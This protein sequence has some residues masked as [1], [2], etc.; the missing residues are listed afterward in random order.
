MF[1]KIKSINNFMDNT[2]IIGLIII[3]IF[4]WIT[5]SYLDAQKR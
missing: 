5:L 4:I 2:Y 3:V 1:K